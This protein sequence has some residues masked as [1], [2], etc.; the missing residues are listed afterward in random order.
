[1]NRNVLMA[2]IV[3][4][5]LLPLISSAP[6]AA[7]Y[8]NA[9]KCVVVRNMIGQNYQKAQDV[10]RAQTLAVL[11]AIDATGRGRMPWIDSSW[12]VVAQS[13]KPGKCVSKYS[14]IRAS[15]KK[16]TD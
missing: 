15:V 4:A 3:G 6:T 14:G 13:P 11:P 1:M 10:W 2:A 9:N 12:Y 16:Y 5:F 7:N 8:P